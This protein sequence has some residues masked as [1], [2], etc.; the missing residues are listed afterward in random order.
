LA[1]SQVDVRIVIVSL[2]VSLPAKRRPRPRIRTAFMAAF[3]S[4]S[5]ADR[6]IHPDNERRM[7]AWIGAR[8]TIE[9][10]ASHA[11]LASK[12]GAVCDRIDEAAQTASTG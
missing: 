9:L 2:T 3:E 7:A 6:T 11:S 1:P 12:P 5:T 8:K 4:V 10:D